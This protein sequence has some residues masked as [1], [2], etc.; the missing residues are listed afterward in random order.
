[1]SRRGTSRAR[2][3][4]NSRAQLGGVQHPVV[5]TLVRGVFPF[6]GTESLSSLEYSRIRCLVFDSSEPDGEVPQELMFPL[7][8]LIPTRR[9]TEDNLTVDAS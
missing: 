8:S 7:T 9:P 3:D 4:A 6:H 5:L 1:M 2:H